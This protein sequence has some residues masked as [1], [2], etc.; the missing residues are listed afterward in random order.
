MPSRVINQF[1]EQA[2]R[3]KNSPAPSFLFFGEL[4]QIRAISYDYA[5]TSVVFQG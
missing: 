1:K 3:L 2:F 5:I 4:A